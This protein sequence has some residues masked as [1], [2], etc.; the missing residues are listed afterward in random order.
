MGESVQ[1]AVSQAGG[2]DIMSTGIMLALMF[3]VMYFLLIR[4]QKKQRDQHQA[5]LAALKKGDE[6]VLA[7]GIYGKVFAVDEQTV[8]VEIADRTRVKVVKSAVSGLASTQKSIT[9]DQGASE[10]ATAKKPK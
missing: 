2:G 4:P 8:V 10:P 5:L 9:G 6:V 3:G 1:V 7:S